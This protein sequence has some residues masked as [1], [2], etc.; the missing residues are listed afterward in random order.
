MTREFETVDLPFLECDFD[1][2]YPTIQTLLPKESIMFDK[3][4]DNNAIM[5]E[6]ICVSIY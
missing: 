4:E 5:C 2:V 3:F 1:T 6:I